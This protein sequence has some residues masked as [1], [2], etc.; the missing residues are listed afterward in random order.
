MADDLRRQQNA[1]RSEAG[2]LAGDR[3]A[4]L[5]GMDVVGPT[6]S[7]MGGMSDDGDEDQSPSALQAWTAAGAQSGGSSSPRRPSMPPTGIGSN[8]EGRAFAEE[9]QRR[10]R[11]AKRQPS[12][13]QLVSSV[14]DRVDH[15]A[16]GRAETSDSMRKAGLPSGDAAEAAATPGAP[17]RMSPSGR[18]SLLK[19]RPSALLALGLTSKGS[20][21]G[22]VPQTTPGSS[23]SP[24]GRSSSSSSPRDQARGPRPS[25]AGDSLEPYSPSGATRPLLSA[26]QNESGASS[27]EDINP[28]DRS[29][30]RGG[31][32]DDRGSSRR[33]QQ[34][35]SDIHRDPTIA[36]AAIDAVKAGHDWVEPGT[37]GRYDHETRELVRQQSP[38]LL[39]Q[40]AGDGALNDRPPS[41][42]M[43][44]RSESTPEDMADRERRRQQNIDRVRAK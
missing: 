24:V 15:V 12:L 42:H 16:I 11:F 40:R 44:G 37:D 19:R 18:Q 32:A 26:G 29:I 21:R 41:S 25:I 5:P 1:A 36:G 35:H 6:G 23:R 2:S 7:P 38:W 30:S 10:S 8:A 9:A 4:A 14:A 33:Q 43:T 3:S 20:F 13:A 31:G 27:G 22:G 34:E 39:S 17:V 28:R